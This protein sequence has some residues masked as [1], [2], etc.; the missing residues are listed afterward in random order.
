MYARLFGFLPA[1]IAFVGCVS[2]PEGKPQ[3]TSPT[4]LSI[5]Q[6]ATSATTTQLSVVVP[7]ESKYLFVLQHERSSS[8]LF[9]KSTRRVDRRGSRW[10]IQKLI[11]SGLKRGENY[12]FEVLG[13]NGE[14]IDYRSLKTIDPTPKPLRFALVSCMDD[15][16]VAGQDEM[17]GRLA[18]VNPD[19]VFFLGDNVY[20]DREIDFY[21]GPANADVIWE[22]YAQTRN[23][24]KFF[25]ERRLTPVIA[26]WDDHD[27]GQDNGNRDFPFKNESRDIFE[28][29]FAQEALPEAIE[30]GPG[31]SSVLSLSGQRFA[32]LDNRT[33]RS[34]PTETN[35]THLGDEQ[36]RWIQSKLR[37]DP[38]QPAQP[39]WLINGDHFFGAYHKQKFESF[40]G[41][42]PLALDRLLNATR[43]LPAPVV[44]ISGDRHLTELSEVPA[45]KLGYKTYELTTSAIHAITFESPW[46]RFPNPHQIEGRSGELN[47]AVVQTQPLTLSGETARLEFNV[48]VYGTR[49]RVLYTRDLSVEKSVRSPDKHD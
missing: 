42:H 40:E 39:V 14:R 2:G 16:W 41:E 8:I 27:Y 23:R 20:A 4:S 13:E 36:E 6:G 31:V 48:T 17:W 15:S 45:T 34:P 18:T 26:T 33:F 11:Y 10:S 22:R 47:F 44:F 28:A 9:P 32:L 5:L 46:D 43:E 1:V 49:E 19:A 25:R 12:H 30:R 24:L 29:Y 21:K 35:G 38:K 37:L 7:H 3:N